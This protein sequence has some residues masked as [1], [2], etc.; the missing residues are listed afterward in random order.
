MKDKKTRK[1]ACN[2]TGKVLF[3]SK[4]YYDKKAL[5][6]G[7]EEILHKTY[8]CKEVRNLLKK[9]YTVT[10]IQHTLKVDQDI[11]CNLTDDDIKTIVGNNTSLRLNTSEHD[12]VSVIRTDPDVKI[13]IDNLLAD[14]E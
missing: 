1:L 10:D 12:R 5:K 4:D 6:A 8:V 3:A 7:T 9:G 13:F 11:K 14:N 2:V